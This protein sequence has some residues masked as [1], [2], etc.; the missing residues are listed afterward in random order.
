VD[1]EAL[2]SNLHHPEDTIINCAK[3]ELIR[4]V[5]QLDSKSVASTLEYPLESELL[6]DAGIDVSGIRLVDCAI[7]RT[8][9]I[10][11]DKEHY[12]SGDSLDTEQW[13]D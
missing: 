9:R 1:I 4:Q 7:V 6:S 11:G 3:S 13:E 10:I 5:A 2:Y 8:Y 12:A